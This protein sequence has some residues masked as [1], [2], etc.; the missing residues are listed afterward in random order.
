LGLRLM[1][2]KN[3][4]PPGLTMRKQAR[5]TEEGSGTCS[6]ISRQVTT[7]N[8]SGISSAR[9]SAVIWRYSTFT[10]DSNW[11]SCATASGAS[12]MSIPITV[13]PRWAMASLRMPP[14]QPTS[15]T[16][17]PARLTRSSIQLTRSGLMSWRGLN[18][19]SRSHQRWAKASNLA[20]SAWSTLLMVNPLN[21]I[22][23]FVGP[24]HSGSE[25]ALFGV[26]ADAFSPGNG[27]GGQLLFIHAGELPIV[28]Q[29]LAGDPKVFHAIAPGGIYKL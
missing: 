5:I 15:S 23:R 2:E 20:I 13:A 7:S 6:S 27:R 24:E 14:P 1:V 22:N 10:P 11:C 9:S 18:S 4:W 26:P 19:L 21:L 12:P 25:P 29:L 28:E 17:L 3:T 16:F 8:C